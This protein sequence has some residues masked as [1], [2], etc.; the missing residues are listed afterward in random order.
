MSRDVGQQEKM[1]VR[2]N[3]SC[4]HKMHKKHRKQAASNSLPLVTLVPFVAI[5]LT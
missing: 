4:G 1:M 3:L 2:I 5:S